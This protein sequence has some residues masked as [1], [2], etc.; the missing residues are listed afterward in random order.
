VVYVH[1]TKYINLTGHIPNLTLSNIKLQYTIQLRNALFNKL[2][3]QRIKSRVPETV[4][5]A[6]EL[7]DSA[8]PRTA[9]R[10]NARKR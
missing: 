3:S 7:E 5:R 4:L 6:F 1:I 8:A 9:N 2:K 10:T